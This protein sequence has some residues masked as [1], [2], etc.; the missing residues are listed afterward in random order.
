MK[1]VFKMQYLKILA[2]TALAVGMALVSTGCTVVRISDGKI[3]SGGNATDTDT[4]IGNDEFDADT[5]IEE[6]W[7]DQILTYV[8]EN[9]KEYSELDEA[10]AADFQTA[11]EEFGQT[12]SSNANNYSFVAKATGTVL[13]YNDES[14]VGYLSVDIQPYDGQ[15]DFKVYVGPVFKG[16]SLRN[17][18][19]FI[20]F[21]DFQSQND[22][23]K[24]SKSLHTK[25]DE[26]LISQL[27]L[28][29][30]EGQ[31]IEV[32]GAF[33]AAEDD[34]ERYLTPVLIQ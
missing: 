22:W 30:L 8:Q 12:R 9:A 25:I 23:A 11:G 18:M 21:T 15:E 3:I 17:A 34:E 31:E 29:G 10:I 7:E 16:D 6:L 27:D 14:R 28:P 24:V 2:I 32:Y 4:Y 33:T 13:E 19:P 26:T 1:K 5:Y 20:K